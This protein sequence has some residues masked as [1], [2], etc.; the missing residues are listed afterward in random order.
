MRTGLSGRTWT[1]VRWCRQLGEEARRGSRETG[2]DLRRLVAELSRYHDDYAATPGHDDTG[3][4]R[5]TLPYPLH[6]GTYTTTQTPVGACLPASPFA[7][8]RLFARSFARSPVRPS[9][10]PSARLPAVYLLFLP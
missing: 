7:R 8:S 6:A 1:R 2:I 4:L 10:H 5:R 3:A 9:V